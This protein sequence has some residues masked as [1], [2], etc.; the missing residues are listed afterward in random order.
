M[1]NKNTKIEVIKS[2]IVSSNKG[3]ENNMGIDK[4]EEKDKIKE[5][6]NKDKKIN[7]NNTQKEKEDSELEIKKEENELKKEI[8]EKRKE[9][10][11]N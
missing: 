9:E 4:A 6:I 8:K 7:S 1:R 11:D 5:I 3:K 2:E 10:K